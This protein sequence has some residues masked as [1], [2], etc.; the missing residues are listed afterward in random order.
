MKP[1]KIRKLV[2]IAEL[3][4]LVPEQT[5]QQLENYFCEYEE[6]DGGVDMITVKAFKKHLTQEVREFGV[7]CDPIVTLNQFEP[8]DKWLKDNQIDYVSLLFK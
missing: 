5:G 1:L 8:I 7:D 4:K 6:L 2:D 3:M